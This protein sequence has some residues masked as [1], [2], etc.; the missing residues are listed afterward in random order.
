MRRYR[1]VQVTAPV[2]VRL[3]KVIYTTSNGSFEMDRVLILHAARRKEKKGE[4]ERHKKIKRKRGKEEKRKR[5][6]EEKRKRGKE[7]KRKQLAF[8]ERG[9]DRLFLRYRPNC[10]HATVNAADRRGSRGIRRRTAN[11]WLWQRR[12]DRSG[13]PILSST[14]QNSYD[15]INNHDQTTPVINDGLLVARIVDHGRGDV[16]IHEEE[17]REGESQAHRAQ[18][19]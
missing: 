9:P 5:G 17:E 12:R 1:V 7:P 14:C 4:E 13:R 11:P 16:L 19:G 2:P 8:P 3:P 6:K 10:A 15:I 18:D